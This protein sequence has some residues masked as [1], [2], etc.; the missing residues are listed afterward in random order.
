MKVSDRI[1]LLLFILFLPVELVFSQ[2]NIVQMPVKVSI[3]SVSLVSFAGSTKQLKDIRN[4][5]TEQ[6]ITPSTLD[7]TWLNYSSIID[8]NSTNSICVNINSG[9]LPAEVV[10]KLN[11]GE[12]VGAGAGTMGKSTGQIS[13]TEYPQ[14]IVTD[15]GTCYTGQGI[16]KGHQL[17]YSW[18]WKPPY[19]ADHSSIDDVKISVICTLAAGK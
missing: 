6:T 4:K 10:V 7:T 15:I 3:P 8:G 17:T 18:E 16:N 19:D 11:V 13:L 14:A 9:Y 12:D 1:L 2:D 5:G